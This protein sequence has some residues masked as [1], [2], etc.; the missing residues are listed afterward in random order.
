M[1]GFSVPHMHGE[2]MSA[3]RLT[4]TLADGRLKTAK[5]QPRV[6]RIARKHSGHTLPFER[7]KST[8]ARLVKSGTNATFWY[9]QIAP[10]ARLGTR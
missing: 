3:D 9:R 1:D 6:M 10:N 7:V 5:E 8:Q 4:K 2:D